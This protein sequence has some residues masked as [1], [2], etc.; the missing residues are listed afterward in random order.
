MGLNLYFQSSWYKFILATSQLILFLL[1]SLFSVSAQTGYIYLHKNATDENSSPNFNFSVTGPSNFNKSYS[2]N[3][4][5]PP[6]YVRDLGATGNGGLY[7]V[8]GNETSSEDI[9]LVKTKTLWF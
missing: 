4:Q 6:L 3:D 7:A 2:L 9:T 1:L 5:H 8:A